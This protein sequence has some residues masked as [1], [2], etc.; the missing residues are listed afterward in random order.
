VRRG[1]HAVFPLFDEM[2]NLMILLTHNF[3]S[4][5]MTGIVIDKPA[6]GVAD[7]IEAAI[8]PRDEPSRACCDR[9]PTARMIQA[10]EQFNS[11]LYWEQHETLEGVWR[12]EKD[13]S[14][15]NFYKGVIQVGVGFHHLTMGNYIG[16]MKV[17]A[18][19]IKYLRPYVPECFGVDVARLR[20]EAG[21]VYLLAKKL[22][23]GRIGEIGAEAL[24]KIHY[25][26]NEVK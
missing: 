1:C 10:F 17:L 5:R 15:R 26:W 7:T 21:A 8:S 9:E 4:S 13:T 14:I 3:R 12:A 20:E 18:R 24:P 16:V 25:H 19:G 22:G 6:Q 23:P 2:C 11:G